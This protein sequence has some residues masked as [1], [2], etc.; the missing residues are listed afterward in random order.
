METG[1]G[2]SVGLSLTRLSRVRVAML[3]VPSPGRRSTQG[4][5]RTRATGFAKRLERLV[6][7]PRTGEQIPTRMA[8]GYRFCAAVPIV[9]RGVPLATASQ[10]QTQTMPTATVAWPAFARSDRW[11]APLVEL[12]VS[13]LAPAVPAGAAHPAPLR[14]SP[15]REASPRLVRL[16]RCED[17]EQGA[18]CAMRGRMDGRRAGRGR[19]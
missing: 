10:L 17:G 8:S 18:C 12:A 1:M 3:Y 5:C 4:S 7:L 16:R 19:E 14:P 15:H 11:L 2:L 6:L 9:A 13:P